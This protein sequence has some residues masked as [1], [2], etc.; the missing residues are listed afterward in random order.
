MNSPTDSGQPAAITERKT[1]RQLSWVERLGRVAGERIGG[2]WLRDR[3]RNL[4][5]RVLWLKTGGKG[6]RCDFPT[7]ESLRLLP[8]HRPAW[9]PVECEGFKAAVRPGSTVLDI[10]ANIGTYTLL[11]G[12]W[13]GPNGRVFAFE[14]APE[15]FAALSRHVALNGLEKVIFPVRQAISD[16]AG[17]MPFFAAGTQ[18]TNRLVTDGEASFS[19]AVQQIETLTIDEFCTRR[20]LKPD[21]IKI[22]IEGFELAALRGAEKTL[23][24]RAR[25]LTVFVEMHPTTWRTLGLTRDDIVGELT[26]QGYTAEPLIP[27]SGD[28]W[29]VEGVCMRL[30][31]TSPCE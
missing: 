31:A 17:T 21:V 10:G 20:S 26:R 22:D 23:R 2:G 19:A 8:E 1:Y 3:L 24:S 28:P 6:V 5:R 16:H 7:G 25:E 9:N 13:A 4:Y 30:I 27:F 14:P 29:Q 18:G 15:T 11:F 12:Q